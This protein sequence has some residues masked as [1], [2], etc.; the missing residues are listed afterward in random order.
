M[1]PENSFST[2]LRSSEVPRFAAPPPAT[3]IG[4]WKLRAERP[5]SDAGQRTG[6]ARERGRESGCLSRSVPTVANVGKKG[7][8]SGLAFEVAD[9]ERSG[10]GVIERRSY[11]YADSS[12]QHDEAIVEVQ[13]CADPH[14]HMWVLLAKATSA[15]AHVSTSGGTA[16]NVCLKQAFE[17]RG[18]EQLKNG[19]VAVGINYEDALPCLREPVS[20]HYERVPLRTLREEDLPCLGRLDNE[21]SV[22]ERPAGD[23][24]TLG[25]EFHVQAVT[26]EGRHR[27]LRRYQA[28]F[29]GQSVVSAKNPRREGSDSSRMG[30]GIPLVEIRVEDKA[31]RLSS[32][33]QLIRI[34]VGTK[35][36]YQD[37][38][39]IAG[40]FRSTHQ[41]LFPLP[42]DLNQRR[43][44]GIGTEGP[45]A[46]NGQGY[47]NPM[48]AGLH[49]WTES[50]SPASRWR[51]GCWSSR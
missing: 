19:R 30:S 4:A 18:H 51:T 47:R 49:P 35:Y 13:R 38:E 26:A 32:Q 10:S 37:A 24:E 27:R 12:V 50:E 29:V 45:T 16:Q 42:G 6:E 15:G 21:L 33:Q 8:T 25:Q 43:R 20:Q 34:G 36:T 9:H 7:V 44:D 2:A 5:R 48:E 23:V 17:Q 40:D 1:P 11:V 46:T 14:G 3:A 39:R 31:C 41:Q 22:A 28:L